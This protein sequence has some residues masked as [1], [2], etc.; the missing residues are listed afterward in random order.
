MVNNYLPITGKNLNKLVRIKLKV[1]S[2]GGS[3]TNREAHQRLLDDVFDSPQ[4][5][6]L[7][8]STEIAFSLSL[9]DFIIKSLSFK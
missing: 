1:Q 2:L 3:E 9:L 8:D 6:A 7:P 4:S 5:T